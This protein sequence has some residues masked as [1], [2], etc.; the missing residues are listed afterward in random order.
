MSTWANRSANAMG[1]PY[2]LPT[3]PP[4]PSRLHLV[5][6]GEVHNPD[7]IVYADLPGFGLSERGLHQAEQ[8]G[9]HLATVGLSRLVSSPLQRAVETATAIGERCGRSVEI[10][11]RLTEWGL[12]GHWAGRPWADV[13]G[14]EL[15]AY[16]EQPE[17]LPFASEQIS[18]VAERMRN[19]VE[20]LQGAGPVALVSH[21]DP[22]QALR[23]SLLG[24]P[25]GL[26]QSEKPGH[27]E[28]ITLG[29]SGT[30]W[31]ETERRCPPSGATPFPPI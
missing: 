8:A 22:V 30:S 29:R 24:E 11:H 4:M 1:P 23:L 16:M 10:D 21:Q 3:L 2:P 27:A 20:S 5:R 7:G 25:L 17:R 19:A 14:S 18:E 28:V 15:A 6:H 13:P 9:S 26:L 12:A 31:I